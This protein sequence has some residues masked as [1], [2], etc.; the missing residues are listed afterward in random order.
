M[1]LKLPGKVLS[2][3]RAGIGDQEVELLVPEGCL[4]AASMAGGVVLPAAHDLR[5]QAQAAVGVA[6][7]RK[8]P[9]PQVARLYQI[10]LQHGL[11]NLH[12]IWW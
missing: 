12:H 5:A 4:V 3:L 6:L 1:T 11:I 8:A 7:P 9:H 10:H 2:D